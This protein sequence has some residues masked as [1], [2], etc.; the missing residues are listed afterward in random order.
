MCITKATNNDQPVVSIEPRVLHEQI[1]AEAIPTT[2]VEVPYVSRARIYLQ[3][4]PGLA[5]ALARGYA[6]ASRR[7][8]KFL[9]QQR[10]RVFGYFV[11]VTRTW[12][13][14]EKDEADWLEA[15][16][17]RKRRKSF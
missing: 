4:L 12:T 16:R 6:D 11:L 10:M 5:A 8:A 9:R 13:Q 17:K 1:G 7:R 2:G 14:V 3:S 15:E